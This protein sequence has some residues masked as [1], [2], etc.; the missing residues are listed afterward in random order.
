MQGVSDYESGGIDRERK[1]INFKPEM[2]C[3]CINVFINMQGVKVGIR[4][5][6]QHGIKII[7][8]LY[9]PFNFFF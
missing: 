5:I 4:E 2:I 1:F 7:D 9:G 8:V 3:S 6:A